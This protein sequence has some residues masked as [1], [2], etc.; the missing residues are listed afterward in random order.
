MSGPSR[1]NGEYLPIG[2]LERKHLYLTLRRLFQRESFRFTPRPS[3][4]QP[5]RI[6][7]SITHI[8]WRSSPDFHAGLRQNGCLFFS[9]S[10]SCSRHTIDC[11]TG[12]SVYPGRLRERQENLWVLRRLGTWPL[13]ETHSG[14]MRT[15]QSAMERGSI[16][17][18][19]QAYNHMH[20]YRR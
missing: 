2:I 20:V 17:D 18:S 19:L 15:C 4:R 13:K 11:R 3:T 12:I 5:I 1:P 10:G 7:R 9:N 8:D 6:K 14:A 16:E